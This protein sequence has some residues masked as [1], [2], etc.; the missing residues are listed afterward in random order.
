MPN[1]P[2]SQL[3]QILDDFGL[4]L[5]NYIREEVARQLGERKVEVAG[6]ETPP[7]QPVEWQQP[8]QP[9]QQSP[10]SE[11]QPEIEQFQPEQYQA[12][13]NDYQPT[14]GANNINN[15]SSSDMSDYDRMFGVLARIKNRHAS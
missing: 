7:E 4:D 5:Q 13:I 1:D 9:E 6:I 14:E 15:T 3:Q 2:A 12:D 10:Q 11:Q 8:E